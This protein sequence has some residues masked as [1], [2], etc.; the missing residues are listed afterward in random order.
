MSGHS[1]SA[2][3]LTMNDDNNTKALELSGPCEEKISGRKHETE[4]AYEV[5]VIGKGRGKGHFSF[6]KGHGQLS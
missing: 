2:D 5:K 1:H 6:E 3:E 4:A